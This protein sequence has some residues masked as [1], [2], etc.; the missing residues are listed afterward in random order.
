MKETIVDKPDLSLKGIADYLDIEEGDIVFLSSDAKQ[1]LYNVY[2]KTGEMPDLNDFIDGIIDKLGET[3][4][5][6]L[7]TYN[8]DF[9]KGK[10]FDWRKSKGKTGTLGNVCLARDDFKRTKHPMYSYAVWGRD[11]NLL[12]QLDYV[13]AFAENSIFG[14]MV[15][16]HAKHV[17]VDVDYTHA[18][19]FVHYVEE[20][21]GN[22]CYR[23]VKYF[24]G[25]YKDENGVI[26]SKSY[27]ML[28]RNMLMDVKCDLQP[29]Q[30]EMMALG[31]VKKVIVNGIPYLITPDVNPTIPYIEEDVRYNHSRIFTTFKGL[32]ENFAN[33]M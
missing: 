4:T 8:W 17:M 9:C 24:K 30:D 15:R 28:V 12:C 18:F 29:L 22:I 27:A 19:T 20:K 16:N 13:S 5:L 3:G 23:F 7:P 32:E 33:E 6:I 21:V 26:S 31:L 14:Y 1:L 10:L 2:E 11:K 25:D